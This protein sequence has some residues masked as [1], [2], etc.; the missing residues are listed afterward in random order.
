MVEENIIPNY[1]YFNFLIRRKRW[2]INNFRLFYIFL[3]FDA[4]GNMT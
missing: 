3:E 2:G 1:S 4:I